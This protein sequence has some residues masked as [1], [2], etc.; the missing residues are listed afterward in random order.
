MYMKAK[1]Y[2]ARLMNNETEDEF[3]KDFESVLYDMVKECENLMKTRNVKSKEGQ[4]SCV[5][6]L[7][8][9]YVALINLLDKAR[10]TRADRDYLKEYKF[11]PDGFR[12]IWCSLHENSEWIFKDHRRTNAKPD[13]HREEPKLMFHKVT[14]FE[15]LTMENITSEILAC[16]ASL[17]SFA[18]CCDGKLITME[19]ARPLAC[20]IALLRYWHKNGAINLDDVKEFE[21]DPLKWVQDHG[22]I[23]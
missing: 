11:L 15:E 23:Q 1:E 20:R 12:D 4:K 19:C 2:F 17:G 3:I 5:L 8:Q 9:K 14:P 7:N 22:G 18:N 21:K 6:E 16:L 10:N 13:I